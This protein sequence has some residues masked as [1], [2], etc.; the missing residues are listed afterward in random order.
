VLIF[1]LTSVGI[2]TGSTEKVHRC[3]GNCDDPV[4]V[5]EL[6]AN[7]VNG[8]LATGPN[9][10]T[11]A[12]IATVNLLRFFVFETI[13]LNLNFLLFSRTTS[14]EFLLFYPNFN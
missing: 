7:A 11:V 3:S 2:S 5:Y 8:T 4:I 9:A 12:R 13:L 1:F 14:S 6:A 10:K